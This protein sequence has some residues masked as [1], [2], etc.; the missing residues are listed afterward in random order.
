[1]DFANGTSTRVEVTAI[2]QYGSNVFIYNDGKAL[3]DTVCM[4]HT[5][6]ELMSILK[7][8]LPDSSEK[9]KRS[10][11][12][13]LPSG[14]PEP[15]A[16]ADDNSISGY[17]LD[18]AEFE[19]V[20]VLF[21]PTFGPDD[22]NQFANKATEFVNGAKAAGKKKL[23][24]DLSFNP[25]GT[26]D[27]GLDLFKLFFP[28]KEIYTATRYRAHEAMDLVGQALSRVDPSSKATYMNTNGFLLSTMVT[29]NQ[30]YNYQSWP[31]AYGPHDELG[32][33][34]SSLMAINNSTLESILTESIRGYGPVKQNATAPP[35]AA[36]D[37]LLVRLSVEAIE[38]RPNHK[39][40]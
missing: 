14:Y 17:Y 31:E 8:Q 39:T 24:I 33:K 25:G 13:P 18:T 6:E 27:C 23:I 34:V 2:Q 16:R 37:I 26:I 40:R 29:P 32:G 36:E 19:D 15:V 28:D 7:G 35:I 22:N 20:A 12:S 38:P 3:F 5:Q 4:P 1:M 9:S 11:T 10:S 30:T 21:I